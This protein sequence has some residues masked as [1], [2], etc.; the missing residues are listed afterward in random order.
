MSEDQTKA[1]EKIKKEI[2]GDLK[3]WLREEVKAGRIKVPEDEKK[4]IGDDDPLRTKE[5]EMVVNR[6]GN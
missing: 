2:L 5:L 1:Y 6:W 3:A 4:E